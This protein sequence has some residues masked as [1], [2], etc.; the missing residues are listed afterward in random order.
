VI[1]DV[2]HAKMTPFKVEE[3]LAGLGLKRSKKDETRAGE[4]Q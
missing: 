1:N 3:V 4:T 2:I